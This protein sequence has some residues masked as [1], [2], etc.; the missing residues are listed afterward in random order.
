MKRPIQ[1]NS[2]K[3]QLIGVG[4]LVGLLVFILGAF[5]L[6]RLLADQSR[7]STSSE[8]GT[9]PAS[10]LASRMERAFPLIS[11]LGVNSNQQKDELEVFFYDPDPVEEWT[12]AEKRQMDEAMF[13]AMK[14]A[15]DEN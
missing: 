7:S 8:R 2:Y 1:E 15:E 3:K 14:F 9:D 10:L 12:T 4:V 5:A 6:I 13:L 11:I